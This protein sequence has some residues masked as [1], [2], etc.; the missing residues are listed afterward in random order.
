[1]KSSVVIAPGG[2]TWTQPLFVAGC[3]ASPFCEIPWMFAA[4]FAE[5]KESAEGLEW[6]MTRLN[7]YCASWKWDFHFYQVWSSRGNPSKLGRSSGKLYSARREWGVTATSHSYKI[8]RPAHVA[9]RCDSS[10]QV[11]NSGTRGSSTHQD[12]I[13]FWRPITSI[14]SPPMI[15][16]LR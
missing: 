5:T 10:Q 16:A 4:A 12:N 8:A 6:R 3:T 15:V 14:S 2:G 13:P 1:M 7:A 11:M 9:F